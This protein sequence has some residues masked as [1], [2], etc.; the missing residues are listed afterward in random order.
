[1][2]VRTGIG[3]ELA[4]TAGSGVHGE[5]PAGDRGGRA[6]RRDDGDEDFQRENARGRGDMTERFVRVCS[7]ERIVFV[8]GG[9]LF[10]N[11]GELQ[12]L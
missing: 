7:S 4:G 12:I 5:N 8:S 11:K 10:V 1:M 3:E 6:W 2:A 9:N